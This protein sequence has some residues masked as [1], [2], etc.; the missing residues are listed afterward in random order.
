M[1]PGR[2]ARGTGYRLIRCLYRDLDIRSPP[3]CPPQLRP[4]RPATWPLLSAGSAAW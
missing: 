1:R 2:G 4:V 3:G